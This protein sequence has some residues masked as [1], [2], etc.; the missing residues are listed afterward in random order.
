MTFTLTLV[1]SF[2]IFKFEVRYISR[3]PF[4]TRTLSL[5][6]T[7]GNNDKRQKKKKNYNTELKNEVDGTCPKVT[8]ILIHPQISVLSSFIK[9]LIYHTY[10]DFNV[11]YRQRYNGRAKSNLHIL[12][13]REDGNTAQKYSQPVISTLKQSC[14]RSFVILRCVYEV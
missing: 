3:K 12:G 13:A 7:F 8:Y 5:C 2:D 4:F 10:V 6:L 14:R 1:V 11:R 9:F